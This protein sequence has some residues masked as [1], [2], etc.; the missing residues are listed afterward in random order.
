ME[1]GWGASQVRWLQK[2]A[3]QRMAAL[4][5]SGIQAIRP[6][7]GPATFEIFQVQPRNAANQPSRSD[8]YGSVAPRSAFALKSPPSKTLE[9]MTR[10]SLN[11]FERALVVISFLILTSP[12]HKRNNVP[13]SL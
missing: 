13:W 2:T 12:I 8:R 9:G 4:S 5:M 6:D 7:L 11:R 10:R 3:I 1:R